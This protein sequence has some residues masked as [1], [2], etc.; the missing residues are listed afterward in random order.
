[1]GHLLGDDGQHDVILEP[2]DAVSVPSMRGFRNAGT[3]DAFMLC[4]LGG[5]DP[6]ADLPVRHPA[7]RR[8]ARPRPGSAR[9]PADPGQVNVAD[10]RLPDEEVSFVTTAEMQPITDW[11]RPLRDAD[12]YT[13]RSVDEAL[14]L[15]S[16]HAGGRFIAGGTTLV[17]MERWG[18]N[19]PP[20]LVYIGR[21]AELKEVREQDGRILFGS[22]ATHNRFRTAVGLGDRAAALL[23]AAQEIAGPAV[24]NLATIG[25]NVYGNWDLV[26]PLLAL[27]ARVHVRGQ[28][29]EA[30]IPL[31]AFYDAQGQPKIQPTDLIVGIDA[32]TDLRARRTRRWRGGGRSHGR[33]PRPGWRSTSTAIPSVRSA[34]ASAG[35]AALTAVD[36]RRGPAARAGADRR[37]GGAG[38]RGRLRVRRRR[39][40]GLR[41]QPLVHPRLPAS[42]PSV[43]STPPPG[44]Q[45]CRGQI[46]KHTIS[47]TLNG[48][49]VEV[50]GVR[51]TA[52]LLEL[53]RDDL[54]VTSARPGCLSGD[55]GCCNV[56]LDGEVVPACLVLAP[57]VEGCEVATVESLSPSPD[58]LS[59]LQEAFYENLAAQCGYCTSG[60]I[61]TAQALLNENP[62]PTREEATRW[63]AGSL[64][65]CTGYYKIIDA[66]LD[67]A[68]RLQPA[69]VAADG[70]RRMER[71][72]WNFLSQRE[73]E[74][75]SDSSAGKE[76]PDGR[77]AATHAGDSGDEGRRA[78]RA[79]GRGRGLVSGRVKYIGDM[80][81]PGMLHVKAKLAPYPNA[82]ITRIDTSK[83]ETHPGVVVVVTRKDVPVSAS[84]SPISRSWSTSTP[85][86]S[87]SRSRPWR[88]STK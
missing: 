53:L 56:L 63:M 36:R 17:R 61:I 60:Q 11:H 3:E 4:I 71:E 84:G 34:S 57:M 42:R 54:G 58:R 18:G 1:M 76:H 22:L 78:A 48:R 67:A 44:G 81:L 43:R 46:M 30:V 86:T 47:F 79:A 50:A 23:D 31:A 2:W 62:N 10:C 33:S 87:A 70:G 59:P 75:G 45:S 72:D 39:G 19:V 88:R 85:A 41:G 12:F 15:A 7:S 21:I 82:R 51:S 9:H 27:E 38:R 20:V 69:M 32:A 49:P 68:Q 37:P 29:G 35:R 77:R 55:C 8:V 24:R 5:G 83:A 52:S 6:T 66:V 73:R 64:C 14:R 26:P 16:E 80:Y 13:A 65:R 25:G 28:G 40:R 74:V